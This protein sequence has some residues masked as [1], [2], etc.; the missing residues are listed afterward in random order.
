[1]NLELIT[2]ELIITGLAG[3]LAGATIVFAVM[4]KSRN[5]QARRYT[6]EN[7]ALKSIHAE[8]I[9]SIE[10]VLLDRQTQLDKT[11]ERLEAGNE[12]IKE[13]SAKCAGLKQK[14]LVIPDLEARLEHLRSHRVE[15]VAA[16]TDLQKQ[17]SSLT[18]KLQEEQ[19][20]AKEK[21]DLLNDAKIRLTDAFK[22]LAERIFEEKGE[23]Y[24]R[25]SKLDMDGV[26]GPLKEQLLEFKRK[27]EDVY[28]RESR[29]RAAL[30]N[31]IGHLKKLNQSIGKDALNLTRALKGDVKTQGMWGE[32]ILSR[33]LEV[34]GLAKGRE[35]DVQVSLPQKNGRRYQPDVIIRMPE[36]R[37]I[38]VDAKVSLTAY[39]RFCS[40]EDEK[41]REAFLKAHMA[42]VRS[43]I[44]NLGEK[45]YHSLEGIRSL[46]FVLMF[47][48]MEAAFF[49]I[50]E[51]DSDLFVKAFEQNIMIVCPSTL[52]VTL[53][54]IHS[55]W[56]KARQ[57]E[58]AVEIARQAGA[59]FDKF[60]G[61][62]EALED[63]GTQLDR[64]KG[65]YQTARDRLA[66]GRGN[67]VGRT[68]KLKEMGIKVKKEFPKDLAAVNPSVDETII[69]ENDIK[70]I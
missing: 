27:V 21:L 43:H 40:A 47:I 5:E 6:A 17:V 3:F 63:V 58:N 34:S 54:T 16:N 38:V 12:V 51:N 64:A 35:F 56:Q 4:A 9:A 59:L 13:L 70:N 22:V 68:L 66:T 39:E 37:D 50:V 57:N 67:L 11:G 18:V 52:L 41:M 28:D 45:D 65:A 60:A 19:K 69:D 31:E 33:I 42:S 2:W 1:M 48:P 10:G 53:R 36:N 20:Q 29:D 61:F 8:K 49:T 26:V 62:A 44:K 7:R 24:A 25:R 46:D 32:V 14:T 23:I 55:L 30:F 15:M